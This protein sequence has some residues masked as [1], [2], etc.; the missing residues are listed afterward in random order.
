MHCNDALHLTY[1]V[2]CARLVSLQ[3]L[4]SNAQLQW[5]GP[6]YHEWVQVG[7]LPA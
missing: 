2:L 7:V 1:R 4:Q 3:L 5:G 6:G